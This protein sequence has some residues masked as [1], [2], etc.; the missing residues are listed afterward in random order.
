MAQRSAPLERA[1]ILDTTEATLRRHGPA[2]TTMLD[3]SR[4]LGVS[5][6]ALYRYFPSKAALVAAV[7]E[8]WLADVIAPL[9]TIVSSPTPARQRMKA[10]FD[11][12]TDTK[13]QLAASDP[14]LFDTYVEL[15]D[16]APEMVQ[17]HVVALLDQLTA[18]VASGVA[19][20]EIAPRDPVVT[21][22]A[23][24]HAMT[25]FHHPLFRRTWTDPD[26]DTHYQAV[27]E[28]IDTSLTSP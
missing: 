19:N 3:V 5:H 20:G 26:L 24:F 15:I 4:A 7:T 25:R 1:T 28:L 11:T 21:A 6:G 9:S 2:K 23:V 17:R 14:E 8:R 10:W 13:R 12:L 27:W 22:Q 18:I 16:D